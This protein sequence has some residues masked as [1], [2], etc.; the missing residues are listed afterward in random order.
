[1]TELCRCSASG[2]PHYKTFDGQ[3]IHYQGVC[4]YTLVDAGTQECGYMTV[5]VKNKRSPRNSKVSL[6]NK[7]TV[8]VRSNLSLGEVKV[9]EIVIDQG[10]KLTVSFLFR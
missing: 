7:V 6:A 2:D 5:N 1:M 10:K 9:D 8:L 4:Q 3:M